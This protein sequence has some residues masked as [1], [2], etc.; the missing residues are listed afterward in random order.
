MERILQIYLKPTTKLSSFC[1][2]IPKN[3]TMRVT[4]FGKSARKTRP[5]KKIEGFTT[6]ELVMVCLVIA[7]LVVITLPRAVRALQLYRLDT[8]VAIISDKLTEAR[9]NAI[10]RNRSA[11]LRIDKTAKTS[12]IKSTNNTG[13]TIDVNFPE[14][15][16]QNLSL[17]AADSV[18][19][20]FDSMGRLAGASQT[21]TIREINSNKR[22]DITISPS[23]KISVGQMY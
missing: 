21:V 7:I 4:K 15:L 9:M 5:S 2:K 11:W 14:R 18:E 8:S 12:Q 6:P 3:V 16:P 1:V 17:E 10:K 22:K 13:Q 19:V 23:G 20:S